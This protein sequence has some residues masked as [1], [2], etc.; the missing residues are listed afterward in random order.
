MAKNYYEVLGVS[1]T[2][3]EKE[4]KT[5]YRRLARKLHPDVNPNDKTAEGKFKEISAAYEVL[6]DD[7]KRTDYDRSLGYSSPVT[8]KRPYKPPPR[9]HQ[10]PTPRASTAAS[11][12]PPPPGTFNVEMWEAWHY[13]EGAEAQPSVK[14]KNSWMNLVRPASFAARVR[15]ITRHRISSP[16]IPPPAPTRTQVN[17]KHQSYFARKAAREAHERKQRMREAAEAAA[18]AE[19]SSADPGE[20]LRMKRDARRQAGDGGG[21]AGQTKESCAVS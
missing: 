8:S 17:N 7:K 15:A 21:A 4:I 13:G 9:P 2:A 5:A 1:K 11:A 14:Q 18:E 20:A 19:A 3:D 6:S 16:A 12:P 10:N